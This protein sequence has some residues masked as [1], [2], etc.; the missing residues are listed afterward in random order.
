MNRET[1]YAS[2]AGCAAFVLIAYGSYWYFS[3]AKPTD[4]PVTE[5][6]SYPAKAV[7][8][9]PTDKEESIPI[10]VRPAASDNAFPLIGAPSRSAPPTPTAYGSAI[11]AGPQ[12]ATPSLQN[13]EEGQRTLRARS[14]P[15]RTV[16]DGK[17]SRAER[18]RMRSSSEED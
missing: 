8:A 6:R 12:K 10:V 7:G 18:R 5:N 11:D 17:L 4:N 2:L 13:D 15:T 16:Q 3:P 1:L 14:R 9:I